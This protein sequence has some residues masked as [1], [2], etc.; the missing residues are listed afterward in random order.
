[1][2]ETTSPGM[3]GEDGYVDA[4]FSD[5]NVGELFWLNKE[6]SDDNHAHRKLDDVEALNIKLQEVIKFSRHQAV[7][8]K[9]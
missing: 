8:Y 6:K 3:V 2:M 1:M 7:F 5:L 9:M 4:K